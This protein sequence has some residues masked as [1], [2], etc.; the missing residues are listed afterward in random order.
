MN[1]L[2]CGNEFK[3]KF[4]KTEKF[5]SKECCQLYHRNKNKKK[6]Y[7]EICGKELTGRQKVNCSPECRRIAKNNRNK[8]MNSVD[9]KKPEAEPCVEQNEPSVEKNESFPSLEQVAKLCN[10]LGLTYGQAVA[11]YGL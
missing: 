5:C 4:R 10:E 8:K 7:C 2:Q 6:R 9:Y 3:Y 11:K 1:C